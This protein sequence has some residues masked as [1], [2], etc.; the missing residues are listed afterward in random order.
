MLAGPDGEEELSP[1]WEPADPFAPSSE[2]PFCDCPPPP[3]PRFLIPPPPA[4][5]TSALCRGGV[6]AANLQFCQMEPI[7]AEFTQTAFPSLPIIAVCSSVVLVAVLV[8]SF[9]L[10]K[11]KRKV[12]NFLPCKTHHQGRCD[13]GGSAG[14]T[15]DDVLINHHPTRLPNHLNPE[16]NTLTPIELLDVKYGNYVQ[17][18]LDPLTRTNFTIPTI[19][20]N[21]QQ[22]IQQQQLQQQQQQQVPTDR[23]RQSR[24]SGSQQH[25]H[26]N[27]HYSNNKKKDHQFHPIYE[28]VSANSDDNKVG[29]RSYDSDIEDSEVEGRTVGSED[30]FAEDELSVA[31]EYPLNPEM[32]Q[33]QPCSATSSLQGSTGG[34]LYPD[35]VTG[36]SERFCSDGSPESRTLK[37]NFRG[38]DCGQNKL[39]H[40]L[41]RN[42]DGHPSNSFQAKQN[43]YL[44][45]SMLGPDFTYPEGV[46]E[47][48]SCVSPSG[49]MV[50][51]EQSQ[52]PSTRAIGSS[53]NFIPALLQQQQRGMPTPS[54]SASNSP[55]P[56]PYVATTNPRQNAGVISALYNPQIVSPGGQQTGR[57]PDALLRELTFK[58]PQGATMPSVAPMSSRS[59][60]VPPSCRGGGSGVL[61]TVENPYPA[62]ATATT[63]LPSMSRTRSGSAT[64]FTTSTGGRGGAGFHPY[65]HHALGGGRPPTPPP[66][67]NIYA[68]IDDVGPYTI[69]GSRHRSPFVPNRKGSVEHR[70]TFGRST[71]GRSSAPKSAGGSDKFQNNV[72]S[73]HPDDDSGKYGD[74]RPIYDSRTACS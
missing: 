65:P 44:N 45:K 24:R 47:G 32:E 31:G 46:M 5:P 63:V 21:T 57:I 54:R 61:F 39:T 33:S 43:Y 13:M 25:H 19:N 23:P 10:W 71:T 55:P 4:P 42:K 26:R 28:E 3:P 50:Q 18:H 64:E 2:D 17:S 49:D 69:D 74:I 52:Y 72:P 6:E 9:L 40:S 7:G 35:V 30:E 14:I 37:G 59:L 58:L 73:R 51:S 66:S 56:P 8:A 22:L 60:P 68:S 27:H 41:E 29:G 38:V 15:Y 36:S 20:S 70:N 48:N 1:Y 12:Q 62:Q 11:H 67:E 34:D 53:L 16:T